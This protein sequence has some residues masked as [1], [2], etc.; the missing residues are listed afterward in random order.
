VAW[1]QGSGTPTALPIGFGG[2]A[3]VIS[4]HELR[5]GDRV[6]FFTEGA[7]EEHQP[8]GER[9]WVSEVAKYLVGLQSHRLADDQLHD[10]AGAAVNPK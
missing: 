4:E 3:P 6:L 9:A 5:R 8:G 10:L 7:I 1:G 2:A